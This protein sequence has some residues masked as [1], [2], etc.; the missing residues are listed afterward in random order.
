MA[1]MESNVIHISN[2][3]RRFTKI[4]SNLFVKDSGLNTTD[5]A[6]IACICSFAD[7]YTG[8]AFPKVET[9]AECIGSSSR[10]V[11][12]SLKR[13]SEKGVLEIE[14]TKKKGSGFPTNKYTVNF[15]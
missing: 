10:T 15:S 2:H 13:L 7:N 3:V 6:V 1:D 5:I 12:R 8:E 14:K 9:I 4:P 11:H